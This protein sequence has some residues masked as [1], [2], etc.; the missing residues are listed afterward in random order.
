MHVLRESSL[1]TICGEDCG[2]ITRIVIELKAAG[3]SGSRGDSLHA[4]L[5]T[6]RR[7]DGILQVERRL[8]RTQRDVMVEM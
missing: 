4:P 1:V 6:V 2:R 5:K 7:R 8:G 3:R